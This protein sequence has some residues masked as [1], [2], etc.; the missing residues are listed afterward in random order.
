MSDLTEQQQRQ[1]ER[2]ARLRNRRVE[3]KSSGEVESDVKHND[4]G[5]GQS[6]TQSQSQSQSPG[7]VNNASGSEEMA[8]HV[9]GV[10]AAER[11]LGQSGR[12]G[13]PDT[14]NSNSKEDA[15]VNNDH[16]MSHIAELTYD[17]R[18]TMRALG[19]QNGPLW[20]FNKVFPGATAKSSRNLLGSV[21][22]MVR[23]A[24]EKSVK[25]ATLMA[26]ITKKKKIISPEEFW[27]RVRAIFEAVIKYK[28]YALAKIGVAARNRTVLLETLSNWI[29]DIARSRSKEAADEQRRIFDMFSPKD[30][31]YLD[32]DGVA[33]RMPTAIEG[34][35]RIFIQHG[36]NVKENIAYCPRGTHTSEVLYDIMTNEHEANHVR[37]CA[38][39]ALGHM[40]EFLE[41]Y[42]PKL[43]ALVTGSEDAVLDVEKYPYVRPAA[44]VCLK[45]TWAAK[46]MLEKVLSGVD[47]LGRTVLLSS[48]KKGY[49]DVLETLLDGVVDVN[50]ELTDSDKMTALGHA[51][52]NGHDEYVKR[53]IRA[54]ANVHHKNNRGHTALQLGVRYGSGKIVKPLFDAG[55][56]V[57]MRDESNR[58]PLLVAAKLGHI[59]AFY[60]LLR[61]GTVDLN[62]R[63]DQNQTVLMNAAHEGN[64]GMVNVICQFV[65]IRGLGQLDKN[66]LTP[67][68][69]AARNGNADIIY[70]LM[71]VALRESIKSLVP[72]GID[73]RATFG[74]QMTPLMYAAQSGH[75]FAVSALLRF[76]ADTEL[77]DIRADG[78]G[79]TA[80]DLA[81][82]NGHIETARVI[83]EFISMPGPKY[84]FDTY[85]PED[86]PAA[87]RELRQYGV[88]KLWDMDDA[89]EVL[90]QLDEDRKNEIAA[91]KELQEL[92][93]EYQAI[94]GAFRHERF[95]FSDIV[96][97]MFVEP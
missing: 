32:F 60:A 30:D 11:L 26:R 41:P 81:I 37:L 86:E 4:D 87:V 49:T 7:P 10:F 72:S 18:A 6:Q 64:S 2:M 1:A 44:L 93:E 48:A 58:T 36:L 24:N 52:A 94:P 47:P 82:E 14:K 25:P 90:S 57:D 78:R 56:D 22:A 19:R 16:K 20:T 62:V 5:P 12:V 71:T 31:K 68:M 73:R 61:T 59:E 28:K 39:E 23:N 92:E 83:N 42:I 65:D 88:D 84:E 66:G 75:K 67:L 38:A 97:H 50:L 96:G 17:E 9:A 45:T 74:T 46:G 33:S 70:S 54:G 85:A 79:Y 51:C 15:L 63:D 43:L 69:M 21:G 77:C 95:Y 91:F 13:V 80:H 89:D 53:I 27:A 55:A 76:G 35:K 34:F 8:A 29:N 40:G 3:N